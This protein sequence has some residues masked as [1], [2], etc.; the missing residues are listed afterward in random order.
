MNP[1]WVSPLLIFASFAVIGALDGSTIGNFAAGTVLGLLHMIV[2]AVLLYWWASSDALQ[3][4][5]TLSTWM[6][7]CLVAFGIVAMPFYLA[8]ARPPGS[9]IRWFP[10]GA[11]LLALCICAYLGTFEIASSTAYGI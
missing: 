3:R 9:W 4:Q 6:I 10:K 7:V 1:R 8:G 2:V 5:A 11:A